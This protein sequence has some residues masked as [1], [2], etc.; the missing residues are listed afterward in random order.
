MMR[1]TFPRSDRDGAIAFFRKAGFVGF[2]DMLSE[3][4]LEELRQAS[5]S[6]S[7]DDECLATTH[8]AIFAIPLFAQY[9]RDERLAK[10]A[11]ELIG[12]PVE[13]YN[14]KLNAKPMMG[15][16]G[17]V[18]AWHQDYPFHPHTNFDCLAGVIHLDAEFEDSGPL[19]VI[20]G[21]HKNGPQSHSMDGEFV[22]RITTE[23][24]A[25][26]AV[27]LTCEQG[28]VIFHHSLLVHY[29]GP[30]KRPGYRRHLIFGYRAQDALQLGGKVWRSTGV[31]V[32]PRQF[33]NLARFPDGTII[34]VRRDLPVA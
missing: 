18:V 29:S 3:K 8:D 26:E 21:S 25:A 10:T 17:G 11:S 1:W 12:A 4:E 15:G 30:K 9:A 34:E 13:L 27:T 19:R 20:P 33:T 14:S 2:D 31:E 32:M 7:Y 24:D 23:I 6:A 28:V 22:G 5:Q 16:D